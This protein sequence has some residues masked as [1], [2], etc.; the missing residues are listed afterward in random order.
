MLMQ[1][2]H[3]W[4]GS[5][6]QQAHR[7]SVRKFGQFAYFDVELG[8]PDWR[9][10]KVLDFGG[11]DGNLLRDRHNRVA[12]EDYTCID[13]VPA[14]IDNGRRAFPRARWIHYDRYNC[15]FNPAGVRGL[16]IPEPGVRYDMILAYSVFTHTTRD[17]MRE[18]VPQLEALLAP[19]GVLAFT[20]EDP[21]YISARGVTNFE[22]RLRKI[23]DMYGNVDVTSLAD[24]ARGAEWSAI[25]AGPGGT[26]VFTNE[27]GT[28]QNEADVCMTYDIYYTAERMQREFK[29]AAVLPPVNGEVQHCCV[30]RRDGRA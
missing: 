9:G 6:E 7:E 5:P 15:S 13:I 4:R 12:Q 11:S 16:A 22:W 19:G 1:E 23:D 27:N 3:R 17:E 14:A 30:I 25:V 26:S 21:D 24:R 28:W 10:R 29:H 8:H 18:L 2:V 20:F